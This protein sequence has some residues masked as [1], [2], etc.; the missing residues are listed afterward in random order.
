MFL[1]INRHNS[2]HPERSVEPD[3]VI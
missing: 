2:S 1:A 3:A